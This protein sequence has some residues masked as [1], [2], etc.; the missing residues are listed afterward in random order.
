[1]AP[2]TQHDPDAY[3]TNTCYGLPLGE[4]QATAM[5]QSLDLDQIERLA[6]FI[7]EAVM[8]AG[9]VGLD[10]CLIY[11]GVGRDHRLCAHFR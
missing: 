6:T 7:F 4:V 10:D 9:P 5:G 3:V 11:Y 8:G 2:K 1:M